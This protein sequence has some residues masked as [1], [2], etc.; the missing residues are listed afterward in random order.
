MQVGNLVKQRHSLS[1]MGIV[2][3]FVN[4]FAVKVHLITTWNKREI[5]QTKTFAI[6]KLEVIK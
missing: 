5:G 6:N 1:T 4:R 2:V 3:G